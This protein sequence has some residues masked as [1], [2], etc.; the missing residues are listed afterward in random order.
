MKVAPKKVTVREV[1]QG[2]INNDEEG[3]YGYNRMLNI[4]PAFQREFVYDSKKRDAV[5]DTIM[6]G[7]PLN[8]MYWSKNDDGTWEVLDG[9]QRTI[10]F[11]EYVNNNY[12]VKDDKGNPRYFENLS[13]EMKDKVLDYEL[14]VYE[15]TGSEEDK[16]RWFET[17]NIAGEKLTN[18]ELRNAVYTG[19]WLT[20]AKEY[21]SKTGCP[22]YNVAGDYLNG[23]AIR[24]DYL[25]TAIKWVHD[26]KVEE[27]MAEHQHDSNANHLWLN[28]KKIIDWVEATFPVYRREMK[29]IDW[30]KLYN[31]HK[32]EKLDSD[33]LESRIKELIEDEDVQSVRGIYTYV[34]NGDERQLKL[35][36]YSNR[37][38]R[39][40]YEEQEGI[41]PHCKK[42]FKF[43]EMEGDHIVPW[44]KGGHT[45]YDNLQMLCMKC[46]RTKSDK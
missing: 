37:D 41:C 3:A 25:E 9:Q 20:S 46:N 19:P 8:V 35:R 2:Y 34:L 4:R 16:L 10:S 40:K 38:K 12:S 1:A 39:R 45:T 7:L 17:I 23:I 43:R 15:T 32:D 33:E 31:A 11:C 5:I 26:G 22:A 27:Y 36:G 13:D 24:Q 44:S 14:L 28:F 6:K 42:E 30:S 29:G 18:Q 21:F